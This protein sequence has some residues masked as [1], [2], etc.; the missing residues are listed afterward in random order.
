MVGQR[1]Q[2]KPGFVD[3]N[4][5]GIITPLEAAE[6]TGSLMTALVTPPKRLFVSFF[7]DSYKITCDIHLGSG[8]LK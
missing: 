6:A 3:T 8:S 5:I 7:H 4:I 2:I 1:H